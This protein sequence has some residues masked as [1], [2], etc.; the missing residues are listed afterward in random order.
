MSKVFRDRDASC[1]VKTRNNRLR[2]FILDND[3]YCICSGPYSTTSQTV[4]KTSIYLTSP[5][6]I[7]KCSNYDR[8]LKKV[9][10]RVLLLTGYAQ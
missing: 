9:T 8:L 1:T 4:T 10:N 7:V 3:N 5:P 6:E 2:Y